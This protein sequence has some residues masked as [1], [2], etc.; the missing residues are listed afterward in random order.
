MKLFLS[1]CIKLFAYISFQSLQAIMQL[2]HNVVMI[3]ID[4]LDHQIF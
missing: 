1:N 2:I 3:K 4:F